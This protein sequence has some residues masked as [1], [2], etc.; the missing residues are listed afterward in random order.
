RLR[1][2]AGQTTVLVATMLMTLTMFVALVVNVGQM[3]NRRVALQLVADAGAWTGATVQANQLNHY[4]FWSRMMQNAYQHASSVAPYFKF[5]ECWSGEAAVGMYVYAHSGMWRAIGNFT[6]L[7]QSEALTHSRF[8]VDDLFPG[9]WDNFSFATR[10]GTDD[11]SVGMLSLPDSNIFPMPL[12]QGDKLYT[13]DH[14]YSRETLGQ[15]GI[16]FSRK[17]I[18]WFPWTTSKAGSGYEQWQCGT[19]LPP[20]SWPIILAGPAGYKLQKLGQP[21]IF[22]WR[23]KEKLPTRALFFDKFFG[24]NAIPAMTAVAVAKAVGGDVHKG[25]STYRAKMVPVT[26]YSLSFGIIRD[27]LAREGRIFPNPIRKIVH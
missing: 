14:D 9:E 4:A 24:P 25:K 16:E 11:G 21:Y 6:G 23:V 13:G 1:A 22:V 12:T 8:N 18:S 26:D 5:S 17:L 10:A 7:A 3:V 2:E 27:P 15:V 20:A 19:L